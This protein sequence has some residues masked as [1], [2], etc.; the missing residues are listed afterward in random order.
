MSVLLPEYC[1]TTP[2]PTIYIACNIRNPDNIMSKEEVMRKNYE[3]RLKKLFLADDLPGQSAGGGNYIFP[4]Y[5]TSSK[6]A[7]HYVNQYNKMSN[8]YKN[9]DVKPCFI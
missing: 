2:I 7:P 4:D 1:G 6:K 5:R 8:V 9:Y 3:L